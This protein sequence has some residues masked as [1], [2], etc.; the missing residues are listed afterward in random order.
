MDFSIIIT[1][2]ECITTGDGLL[3][4][5]AWFHEVIQKAII[6]PVNNR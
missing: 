2:V 6:V 1:A 3:W 4:K 5:D